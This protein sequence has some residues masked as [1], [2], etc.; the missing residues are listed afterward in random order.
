MIRKMIGAVLVIMTLILCAGCRNSA[1]DNDNNQPTPTAAQGVTATPAQ[2][3]VYTVILQESEEE[4]EVVGNTSVSV[5]RGEAAVFV[6]KMKND[7]RVERVTRTGEEVEAEIV[8]ENGTATIT[9][10]DVRFSFVV[11]TECAS[12]GTY[13]AYYPNGGKYLK[14]EDPKAPL[15]VGYSINNRLRPNT[16]T[17]VG[18]LERS[19][20]ILIGWNTEPDGS[21][22]HIGL[23]SRATVKEGDTTNL[24]AEWVKES[25]VTEFEFAKEDRKAVVTKY[26]GTDAT[27]AV[28]SILDGLPITTIAEGAFTGADTVRTVVLPPSIETVE[29]GAFRDSTLKELYLSDNIVSITD[30]SFEGCKEFSTV[31]INAYDLPRC[32]SVLY[33]EYNFA[34]KYDILMLHKDEK[35]IVLF[36]G[37]GA[38]FSTDMKKMESELNAAG[39][40][41]ICINMA[42]NG[43][44]NGPAQFEMIMPFLN[45]GDIFLHAPESS[46]PFSV[47]YMTTMTPFVPGFDYNRI[48]IY[49]CM[50]SNYDLFSL[51]D[52]RTV[53]DFFEGLRTFFEFRK[54]LPVHRYTDYK[55]SLRWYADYYEIDLGY[56]DDRGG[57]AFPLKPKESVES[58]EADIVPEYVTD[59]A[60]HNRLNAFYDRMKESGVDVL[61]TNAPINENALYMRLFRGKD[62]NSTSEGGALYYGRAPEI[63]DPDFEDLDTWVKAYEDAV[64]EY[65]HCTVILPLH[66]VLYDVEYFCE[67]DYHLADEKKADY[68]EKII[69]AL[70]EY[71]K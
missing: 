65:L 59:E 20:W 58:G 37:S 60:A 13:I 52:L 44:F 50:E 29:E 62:F 54:I 45:E 71:L 26:T 64:E 19:G 34:D 5:K 24:Y 7:L 9:I 66:E 11:Y 38:Y 8:N 14:A 17:A 36:G 67:P 47:M 69:T 22:E 30:M 35:K 39:E 42:V 2:E 33:S 56:I 21:G 51:V 16:E 6:L 1:G 23:G 70:E 27:V 49:F 57:I 46:S 68:T 18:K 41:Y 3:P 55:D 10:K 4:F 63:P 15:Y 53:T 31:H 28:P 12:A 61:F 32:G 25:D 48:R 43:W 40:D